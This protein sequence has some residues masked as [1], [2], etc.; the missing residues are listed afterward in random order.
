MDQDLSEMDLNLIDQGNIPCHGCKGL[1][2]I[3][4]Q[5]DISVDAD[6]ADQN[7]MLRFKLEYFVIILII[8][9]YFQKPMSHY[10]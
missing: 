4:L 9:F 6:H 2:Q 10:H 1:F 5:L 3:V 7:R 8:E